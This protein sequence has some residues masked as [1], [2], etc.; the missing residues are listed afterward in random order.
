M[1]PAGDFIFL[2]EIISGKY[3]QGD[4]NDKMCLMHFSGIV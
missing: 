2:N 1:I 3:Y 4:K